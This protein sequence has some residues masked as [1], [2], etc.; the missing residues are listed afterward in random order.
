M[1]KV[2]IISYFHYESSLCLAKSISEQGKHVDCYVVIDMHHD[3]G[4]IPGLDYHL[5]SKRPGLV[6]LTPE[7]A[8]E[9]YEYTK[10]LPVNF[11]LFRIVSY[12]KRLMFL[13]R[14]VFKHV[15]KKIKE[16]KYDAINIVGQWSWV[17]I[18]H[19]A[20][21][22]QN[23]THTFHEIGSHF[24]G[25][26]S[27]PLIQAVI[28]DNSKVIVPSRSTLDRFKSIDSSNRCYSRCIPFGRFETLLLY[29]R[30]TSIELSFN[31]D[32]PTF[33]YFGYIK[34]YKG[35]DLLA[36]ACRKL[37]ESEVC[38]NLI[39]AGGGDD[40]NLS[41]FKSL[42]NCV[43]INRFMTDDEMVYLNEISDVVLLPYKTA[44][45]SGIVPTSFMFGNPIIATNVGALGE[46]IKH[47]INGI[48]VEPDNPTC[49][50]HA[51]NTLVTDATLLKKLKDGVAYFGHNDEYDWRNIAK[52]TIDVLYK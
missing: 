47:N 35:L 36:D 3:T 37:R 21:K 6:K 18:I 14:L 17:E 39:V 23:I 49:F 52:E 26:L 29:K 28:R 34:P 4:T 2:A 7:T 40:P 24:N 44:S 41:F 25:G 19:N 30:T 46:M 22:K 43:V 8:P 13:N 32:Y 31:N 20:L 1:Q 5:A 16:S 12:S 48:L 38:Y 27:T 11:Y 10:G 33:L 50:A 9:I 15:L 45:Q 51:I 42:K